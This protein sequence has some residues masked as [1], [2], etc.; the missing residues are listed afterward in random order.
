M[1]LCYQANTSVGTTLQMGQHKETI[2]NSNNANY[3][4]SLISKTTTALRYMSS[5]RLGYQLPDPWLMTMMQKHP[6]RTH[7]ARA[8]KYLAQKK[9]H[10]ESARSLVSKGCLT[11]D[12]TRSANPKG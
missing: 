2:S 5:P 4:D 3:I 10:P 9:N 11:M 7:L 6:A 12:L 1:C 8:K